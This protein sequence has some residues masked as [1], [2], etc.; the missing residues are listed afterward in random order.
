MKKLRLSA[1][2]ATAFICT[3]CSFFET[4]ED[5]SSVSGP[6]QSQELSS[7]ASTTPEESKGGSSSNAPISS[8]NKCEGLEQVVGN[9]STK[10]LNGTAYNQTMFEGKLTLLNLWGTYCGPCVREM[11]YLGQY[12]RDFADADFQVVGIVCDVTDSS[13]KVNASKKTQA[14]SI[15]T[16]TNVT[17]PSLLPCAGLASFI[18]STEYIPYSVFIDEHGHQLGDAIT[19]SMS[20]TQW[21]KAIIE[22]INTYM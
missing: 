5:P 12:H 10:D 13:Y 17:Y 20:S 15:V 2:L 16:Q 7:S 6:S 3:S 4:E 19:G 22:A 11:P 9:F 1:L 14:D 8:V 21:K 18:N